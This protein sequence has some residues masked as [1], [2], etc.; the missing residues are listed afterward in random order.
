MKNFNEDNIRFINQL[1]KLLKQK[2]E[3]YGSFD[4]TSWVM[5]Q[6]LENVLTAHNGVKVKVS[7]KIFGIFMIMLKLWRILSSKRYLKDN[8]D[9]I[10]GYDELLRKL[11]IQEEKTNGK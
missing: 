11:V 10:A 1:D 8:F 4:R 9:D 7:I 3:D 6:L 2:E 5:T